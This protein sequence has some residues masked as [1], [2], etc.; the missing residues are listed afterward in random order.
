MLLHP[1]SIMRAIRTSAGCSFPG[2]LEVLLSKGSISFQP[3]SE[4]AVVVGEETFCL[5]EQSV[6][7][8]QLL[9]ILLLER[10]RTLQRGLQLLYFLHFGA[11]FVGT[12]QLVV[13]RL[14]LMRF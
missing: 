11:L 4:I 1:A 2:H 9:L 8:G 5:F 6:G 3:P 10:Q 14:P 7:L 13:T 12:Q